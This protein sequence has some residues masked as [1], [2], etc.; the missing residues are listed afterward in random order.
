LAKS[1]KPKAQIPISKL[2]FF[3]CIAVLRLGQRVVVDIR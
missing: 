2:R 3:S 1:T